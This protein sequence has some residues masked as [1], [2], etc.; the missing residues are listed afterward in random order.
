MLIADPL[1]V[2]LSLLY[3]V[4][5]IYFQNPLGSGGGGT[6]SQYLNFKVSCDVILC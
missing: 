5:A 4:Y 1:L 2:L 6:N 3:N